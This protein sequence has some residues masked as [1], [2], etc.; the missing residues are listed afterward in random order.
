MKYGT[1]FFFFFASSAH[2]QSYFLILSNLKFLSLS[3]PRNVTVPEVECGDCSNP[4]RWGLEGSSK[5][6]RPQFQPPPWMGPSPVCTQAL[7]SMM[8]TAVASSLSGL[9]D[10]GLPPCVRP[11]QVW[12]NGVF[13]DPRHPCQLLTFGLFQ[14][15]PVG[16]P[17]PSPICLRSV[18]H[19]FPWPCSPESLGWLRNWVSPW[20]VV[21]NLVRDVKAQFQSAR[22]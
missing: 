5:E 20:Q 9:R 1:F 3:E 12:R 4:L 22:G 7:G 10:Y 18:S 13:S 17:W 16:S 2:W 21:W 19:Q 14:F 8:S 6:R 15:P 11:A